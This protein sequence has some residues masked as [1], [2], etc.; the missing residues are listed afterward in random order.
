MR[1]LFQI[2][3]S[4]C[5]LLSS[6]HAYADEKAIKLLERTT[7]AAKQLNYDGVFG[8]QAGDKLQT[9]RII[10][11]AD[12][13]GEVERLISL[14]GIERELIRTNDMVTCIYPEG[15]SVQADRRPLGRGF[16]GDLLSRL[17][18]ASAYYDLT[19]G[20]QSR[21]AGYQAQELVIKPIDNYRYGYRLWI[22]KESDLL[23]QSNLISDRG[24]VL[25][26]FSFSSVKMGLDI[27]EQSL[28][29]QMKGNEMAW[30][31]AK[32]RMKSHREIS[33]HA[34]TSIWKVVWLPEGFSLIKQQNR[35]KAKNGAPVE[36][37]VYSDGLSSISVFIEKIRARHGHLHG[38]S[39]MGAVNVFGTIMDA[40]FVTVVGEVPAR[41]VEKIGR[42][43]SHR[44]SE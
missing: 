38:G 26:K 42:S 35:L 39:T 37:R 43:I 16:P 9:V 23:L 19:L 44:D 22:A 12:V 3:L 8:F 31:R 18:A 2:F 6:M 14:N 4:L 34:G 30:H 5:L 25:E 20:K 1:A 10:H 29:P 13:Q 40:H 32:A 15:E 17:T 21:V 7:A 11:R 27:T 36:Q 41:T 28:T 33:A 24:S